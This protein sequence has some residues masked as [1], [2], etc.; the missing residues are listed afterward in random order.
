MRL[1]NPLTGLVVLAS[2]V[3]AAAVAASTVP[4]PAGASAS[5]SRAEVSALVQMREEEKLA[6]DVYRALAAKWNLPVFRNIARAAQQHMNA[7]GVLLERYG[8]ADPAA[9]KAAGQAGGRDAGEGGGIEQTLAA[10][11]RG[12]PLG[13][14]S[15]RV[16]GGGRARRSPRPGFPRATPFRAADRGA[17]AVVVGHQLHQPC[18]HGDRGDAAVPGRPGDRHLRL[19]VRT[20]P[21]GRVGARA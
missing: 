12:C 3:A 9:G 19:A 18:G 16:S 21:P 14:L 7:V 10:G 20:L 15:R 4:E 13:R 5:L 2:L 17:G 11:N 6:R 8:I 1:A